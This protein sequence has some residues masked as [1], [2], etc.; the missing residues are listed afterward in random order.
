MAKCHREHF[1]HGLVLKQ[2]PG[3][4]LNLHQNIRDPILISN[5]PTIRIKDFPAA[6]HFL[7][8]HL[9]KRSISPLGNLLQDHF[10]MLPNKQHPPPLDFKMTWSLIYSSISAHPSKCLQFPEQNTQTDFL[11]LVSSIFI[12]Y[13]EVEV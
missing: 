9:K 2:T 6:N 13:R 4:L 5:I 3:M 11:C 8:L 1:Y 12:H 10:Q 7:V